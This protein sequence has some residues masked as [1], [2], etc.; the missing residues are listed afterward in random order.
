MTALTCNNVHVSTLVVLGRDQKIYPAGLP[1]PAAERQRLRDLIHDLHC[2]QGLSV[3]ATQAA[4]LIEHGIRRSRGQVHKYLTL[5]ECPRCS[6]TPR[7]SPPPDPR[8]RAR[9]VPWR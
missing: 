9:P 3:R 5:F 1:L 7:P 2:R 8:M 4:L 6:T